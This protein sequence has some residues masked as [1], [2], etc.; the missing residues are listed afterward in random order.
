MSAPKAYLITIREF[1]VIARDPLD[2]GE[3]VAEV[4]REHWT[5]KL[6]TAAELAQQAGNS[7]PYG[8][9]WDPDQ[10][11]TC[12]EIAAVMALAEAER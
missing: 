2:V 4:A 10:D 5:A 11:M 12:R 8:E 3:Y 9:D 1:V 6:M 7:F